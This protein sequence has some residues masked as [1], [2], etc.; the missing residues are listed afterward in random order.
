MSE[1]IK[2]RTM[3]GTMELLPRGQAVLQRFIDRIRAGYERFGFQPIETPAIEM[4]DVLLT[5]SGGDTEKQ[6]YFVQSTGAIAQGHDPKLALRF[7]LTV[8]LAR[9]VAQHEHDLAFPFRRYQIQRVYRGESAQRGRF[10]EFYQCDIDVV[11]KDKLALTTDAEI[12]AVIEHVFRSLEIGSFTI[13]ISNRKILRGLLASLGVEADETRAAILREVDK[14]DKRG[15]AK[16]EETLRGDQFGLGTDALTTLMDV[17]ALRGDR[18]ATVDQLRALD[19]AD[20]GF[21]EG[22][23]E[24]DAVL[25]AM[26]DFGVDPSSYCANLAIARGLDYYTGTVYETLLDDHP[27]VGSI[28]SGGRYDDLA[29]LYTK[30]KLPGVGISIGLTRLFDQLTA[31]GV[32][33]TEAPGTTEVLVTQMDAALAEHG[34]KCASALRRAGINTELH[35]EGWKLVKQ[36][37]YATKA[38]IRFAVILGENEVAKGTAMLKDLEAGTQNEVSLDELAAA[39]RA[40]DG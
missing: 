38:G 12:P 22:V 14:I 32:I 4:R 39:V 15:R 11:G 26:D 36:F 1:R 30:S 27:E 24:L 7:D 17:I 33:N 3:P 18:A 10:R 8:P 28:C 20:D 25:S 37:K 19:V 13:H 35:T 29:S 31:A 9:Y 21:R 34:R 5:K 40:S 16:V 6:V 2:P 23:D